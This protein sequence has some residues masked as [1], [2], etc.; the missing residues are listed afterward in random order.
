MNL[1]GVI[2]IIV[3][4]LIL[5]TINFALS[6][7]F[8]YRKGAEYMLEEWKDNNDEIRH[9]LGERMELSKEINK[10]SYSQEEK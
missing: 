5:S 1:T 7:R 8:G 10:V 4:A 3:V 2:L 6:Y 9:I